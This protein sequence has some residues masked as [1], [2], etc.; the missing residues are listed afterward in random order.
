MF[1]RG[2]TSEV[3]GNYIEFQAAVWRALPRDIGPDVMRRC[4]KHGALLARALKD[5][6]AT[7]EG[8]WAREFVL[9]GKYDYVDPLITDE[10]FPIEEHA[11]VV[12]SIVLFQIPTVNSPDEIVSAFVCGGYERPTYEDAFVFGIEQPE[13]Q[14]RHPVVF[15]HKPILVEGHRCVLM[16]LGDNQSRSLT[17]CDLDSGIPLPPSCVFA[18]VR[19]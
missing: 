8:G 1:K 17:L 18:A 11:S 15:L 9:R 13:E 5:A 16:L 2:T 10:L 19:K 12:R 14:R 3:P 4:S 6:L 7:F